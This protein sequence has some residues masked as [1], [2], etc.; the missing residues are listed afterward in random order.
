MTA[1][2]MID[3]THGAVPGIPVSTLK[4]AGYVTGTPDVQWT[5]TDWARFP[6]SGHVR[7]DQSAGGAL[8]TSGAAD[9]LD[10]ETGA[11]TQED[12]VTAIPERQKHGE[13]STVYVAQARLASLQAA[14][15]ELGS[16]ITM[17]KVGFWVANW[18]LSETEAD[19][20][21]GNEIVAVQWASPV[22]NPDTRVPGS[23]LTL[24]QANLDLS[25]TQPG[26]FPPPA[27]PAAWQ[28]QALDSAKGILSKLQEVVA[29]LGQH[30]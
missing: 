27:P 23:N 20:A 11:A 16:L 2:L 22:S 14:L 30:Q 4:I 12:A 13:Y 3:G 9:V 15:R 21:L 29:L 26:W 25:V 18:N 19:A 6:R 24:R 7:I 1:T 5:A 17:N 8:F 28:K 10:V